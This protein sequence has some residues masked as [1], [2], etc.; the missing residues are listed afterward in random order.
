MIDRKAHA[1]ELQA[2]DAEYRSGA[3]VVAG[4]R[5]IPCCAPFLKDEND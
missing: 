3:L 2:F 5:R 1:L 4:M